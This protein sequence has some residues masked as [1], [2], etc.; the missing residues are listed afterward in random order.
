MQKQNLTNINTINALPVSGKEKVEFA[1]ELYQEQS[2]KGTGQAFVESG[3]PLE[4]YLGSTIKN[5]SQD[6][7]AL[8]DILNKTSLEDINKP[9]KQI[10][11]EN[12]LTKLLKTDISPRRS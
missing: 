2:T 6:F 9:L 5:K 7:M 11:E 1:K 8:A 10:I 12:N 4:T 3:I